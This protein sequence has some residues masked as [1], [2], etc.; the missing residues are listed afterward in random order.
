MKKR[1]TPFLAIEETKLTAK[2]LTRNWLVFIHT[3]L[4]H[5]DVVEKRK[6]FCQYLKTSCLTE[7]KNK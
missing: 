7:I 5:N 3:D 6:E 2:E 4:A 1:G